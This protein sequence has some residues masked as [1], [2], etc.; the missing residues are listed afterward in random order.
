[1]AYPLPVFP[2]RYI[3]VFFKHIGIR[4]DDGERSF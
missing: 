1:M 3:T 2:L 4:E